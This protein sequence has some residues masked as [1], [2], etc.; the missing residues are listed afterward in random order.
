[1]NVELGGHNWDI[2]NTYFNDAART[3]LTD[4]L[5]IIAT[6]DRISSGSN[7][8]AYNAQ[9]GKLLWQGEVKQLQVAHS[10]YYNAVFLTLFEDKLILEGNEAGGSYL[11]VL[12]LKSGKNLFALME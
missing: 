3:I 1:M 12:D 9:T 8:N 4:S 7:V 11:Q 5:L 2:Q 6:F 10:E